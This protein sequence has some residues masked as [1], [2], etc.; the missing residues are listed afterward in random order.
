MDPDTTSQRSRTVDTALPTRTIPAAD[1][2]TMVVAVAVAATTEMIAEA[3]S[4]RT[5]A[6]TATRWAAAAVAVVVAVDGV[7]ES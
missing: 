7:A 1:L 5:D 4:E 3:V 2:P 6:C